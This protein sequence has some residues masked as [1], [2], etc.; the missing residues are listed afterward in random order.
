MCGGI[1]ILYG[2]KDI[3]YINNGFDPEPEV[4]FDRNSDLES[5]EIPPLPQDLILNKD[6][7]FYRI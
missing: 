4:T 6:G 5:S 1:N 3:P 7:C 2:K